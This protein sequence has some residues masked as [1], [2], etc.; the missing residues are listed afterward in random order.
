MP[1]TCAS[2]WRWGNSRFSE[3]S[4]RRGHLFPP[5]RAS[6][7]RA[8]TRARPLCA[9]L[10]HHRD[11]LGRCDARPGRRDLSGTRCDHRLFSG[12]SSGRW[13]AGPD[14][15]DIPVCS[16]AQDFCRFPTPG[17]GGWG[18]CRTFNGCSGNG[19]R[20]WFQIPRS[21]ISRSSHA[22]AATDLR[23]RLR[24]AGDAIQIART[25]DGVPLRDLVVCAVLIL[26]MPFSYSY[27][28]LPALLA[29]GWFSCV[30]LFVGRRGV[31][32][33]LLAMAGAAVLVIIW[34]SPDTNAAHFVFHSRLPI[35]TPTILICAILVVP[36]TI[37]I[38]TPAAHSPVPLAG[39]WASGHPNSYKQ[40]ADPN[41]RHDERA[42]L[43]ADDKR[44]ISIPG[45]G[46]DCCGFWR[47][48]GAVAGPRRANCVRQRRFFA[49]Q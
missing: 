24:A 28:S 33:Y 8:G 20:Y 1:R 2:A 35:A 25:P 43:G 4:L 19:G 26:L 49:L 44:S 48:P 29:V 47:R 3:D 5:D 12:A 10:P 23:H 15:A 40:S 17:S 18:G 32:A 7:F 41:R 6:S 13:L 38:V 31:A 36:L 45:P 14:I 39:C 9:S 42:R 37:W 11:P 46:V 21:A 16:L 27:V 30:L 34:F 22:G